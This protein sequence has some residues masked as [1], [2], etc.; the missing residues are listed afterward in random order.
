VYHPLIEKTSQ[1]IFRTSP[2]ALRSI[3]SVHRCP[4]LLSTGSKTHHEKDIMIDITPQGVVIKTETKHQRTGDKAQVNRCE[5]TAG[6][7]RPS[8]PFPTAID[9]TTARSDDESVRAAPVQ[10]RTAHPGLD[11]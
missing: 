10:K 6:Q 9:A 7:F 3:F 11:A 4:D 1:A 8:L 5:F 2:S